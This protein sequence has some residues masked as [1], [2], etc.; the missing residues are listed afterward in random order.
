MSYRPV[1]E[2]FWTDPKVRGLSS[3]EKLLFLYFI[4]NPHASFTGLYYLPLPT[5]FFETGFSEKD[6][7]KGMD[8]LSN[9]YQVLHDEPNSLFWVVKMAKF[10]V[11]SDKQIAG[12]R[13]HVATLQKSYLIAKFAERYPT[14]I[15]P[16]GYPIDTLCNGYQYPT[17]TTDRDRETK[18]K[19]KQTKKPLREIDQDFLNDLASDYPRVNLESERK[20]AEEWI[21]DNP[22]RKFSRSFF[23]GWVKR[24]AERMPPPDPNAYHGEFLN[25][26]EEEIEKAGEYYQRLID[27]EAEQERLKK[28]AEEN[29]ID[30]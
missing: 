5:L 2:A 14:F 19:E 9:G 7:R 3:N 10:Q 22:G 4:T 30:A 6:F 28:E 11:Q 8:T 21:L 29:E 16:S 12:V 27:A 15:D 13:K 20:L 25:A 17:D 18:Q 26:E 1:D 24:A 23:R